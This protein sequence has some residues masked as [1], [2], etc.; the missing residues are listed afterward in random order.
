MSAHVST[1]SLEIV[2][3][4]A[5]SL[6]KLARQL[7][8]GSAVF[9]PHIG[10]KNYAEIST[11][12]ERVLAAGFTPVAHLGARSVA[13]A[14]AARFALS[15]LQQV[16]VKDLLLLGGDTNPPMGPYQSSLQLLQSGWL[17]EY[18]MR[19]CGFAS[20]P[21]GKPQVEDAELERALVD[22]LACAREQGLSCY[23]VSQFAFSATP[24]VQHLEK[25]QRLAL[26]APIY[27]GIAGSVNMRKL[28]NF[29]RQCGVGASLKNLYGLRATILRLLDKSYSP[30]RLLLSIDQQLRLQPELAQLIAGVHIFP[31]GAIN[32]SLGDLRRHAG[33]MKVAQLKP[34]FL[35]PTLKAEL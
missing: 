29:A 34:R 27:L 7:P 20:H 23:L 32:T 35:Q 19:S 12:A 16:G 18:G 24:Y 17:P 30:G 13:D 2:N 21:E 15:L 5:E 26:S 3:S 33:K 6:N 25:L 10:G 22:K 28:M 9:V 31:F 11:A 4:K 8:A 14:D 1:L